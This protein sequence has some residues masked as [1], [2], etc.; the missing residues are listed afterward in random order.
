MQARMTSEII[1]TPNL[2]AFSN[3]LGHDI[4]WDNLDYGDSTA[5]EREMFTT[6]YELV[7]HGA[8][9]DGDLY[10]GST[11]MVVIRRRADGREFGF[12]YWQGGGKYGEAF[13]ETN[14]DEFADE[15]P[16][17]QYDWDSHDWKTDPE[18][19]R[20]YVFQ[21]VERHSLPAYRFAKESA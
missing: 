1:D 15:L 9:T 16:E 14:G 10:Q 21:P 5:D 2:I 20:W 6:L 12:S 13:P 19:P 11:L 8:Q 3:E 17:I 18:V 7:V 4:V